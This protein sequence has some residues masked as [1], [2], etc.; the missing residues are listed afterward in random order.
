MLGNSNILYGGWYKKQLVAT[1]AQQGARHFT[2]QC[3]HTFKMWWNLYR[4]YH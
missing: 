4:R 1:T 3:C 2:Q